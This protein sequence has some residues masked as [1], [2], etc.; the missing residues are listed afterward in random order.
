MMKRRG[1]WLT[2]E[3]NFGMRW[4]QGR[5]AVFDSLIKKCQYQIPP[6]I[7]SFLKLTHCSLVP[8]EERTPRMA[9]SFVMGPTPRTCVRSSRQLTRDSNFFA[10]RKEA[11][12]AL[13][14]VTCQSPATQRSVVRGAIKNIT[15]RC[16]NQLELT[17]INLL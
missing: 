2:L 11:S 4:R 12:D 17:G 9:V 10:I 1:P 15:R 8:L 16:V 14:Q 7:L 3:S 13:S 6:L 5:R